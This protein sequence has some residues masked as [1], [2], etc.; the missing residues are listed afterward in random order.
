MPPK[1]PS[2]PLLPT[3]PTVP[4]PDWSRALETGAQFTD[5]VAAAV[6]DL[7]ELSRRRSNDLRKVVQLGVQRQLGALGLATKADLVALERRVAKLTRQA[8]KPNKGPG[9]HKKDGSKK[10][11]AKADREAG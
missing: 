3:I 7:I 5:Q 8:K 1:M 11:A 6:D 10:A 4:G 2:M 9:K